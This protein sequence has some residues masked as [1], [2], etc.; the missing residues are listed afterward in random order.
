MAE[1]R[2]SYCGLC[3][4]RCGLRLHL[5]NGRIV[6]AQGDPD[7]PISRGRLCQRGGL[8]VDH[9][10]HP[11]RINYPL[12]RKG[13]RGAAKWQRLTWDQ[14]LDEVADKLGDLRERYGAETLA[15]RMAPSEPITGM[16]ADFSTCSDPPMSA[17]PTISACA[18]ARRWSLQLIAALPRVM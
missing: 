11:D 1:I 13:A 4:S 9:V 3:H 8:M 14:A 7:H 16:S 12:K 15:S 6:K 17:G 2:R 18:R 10:Y 5:E